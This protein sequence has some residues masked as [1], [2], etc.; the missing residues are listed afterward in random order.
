MSVGLTIEGMAPE[1]SAL[2][3]W[4]REVCAEEEATPRL[5]PEGG[6]TLRLH[7]AG[8]PLDLRLGAEGLR[9]SVKTGACGPGYHDLV[10]RVLRGLAQELVFDLRVHD[11][12]GYYATQDLGALEGAIRE[13]RVRAGSEVAW[14][15]TAARA[16]IL[17]G[18]P[19]GATV[20]GIRSSRRVITALETLTRA[21]WLRQ[22]EAVER[23]E[24][25]H[26]HFAWWRLEKDAWYWRHR[27]VCELHVQWS[28]G[29]RGHEARLRA[30]LIYAQRARF[31]DGSVPLPLPRLAG[32]CEQLGRIDD[33]IAHLEEAEAE[34][35]D[36]FD[37]ILWL[38]ELLRR[39]GRAEE[40]AF[41][42]E[43]LSRRCPSLG[44]VAYEAGLLLNGVEEFERAR[45]SLERA[46]QLEPER[47]RH[48]GELAVALSALG[49]YEEALAALDQA[50]DR[51]PGNP[52]GWRN[53]A[54]LL[55][56][57]GRPD[58]ATEATKKA[59]AIESGE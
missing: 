14:A 50:L 1:P 13:W 39:A 40:G 56:A 24:N 52:F 25:L 44:R 41:R 43:A 7:P 21:A 59:D 28:A 6:A 35:P 49:L 4:A 38:A 33:A 53:R 3:R 55:E 22:T 23:G 42:V 5:L 48:H 9:G 37:L 15:L 10:C 58:E 30:A 34:Q 16:P 20:S 17:F 26:E 31:L 18:L 11:P 45:A 27:A 19:E 8:D 51:Q 12:T 29:R 46:V 32:A 47:P 36:N 2:F 54:S 57:L